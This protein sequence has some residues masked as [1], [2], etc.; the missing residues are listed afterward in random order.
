MKVLLPLFVFLFFNSSILLGQRTI[1]SSGHGMVDLPYNLETHDNDIYFCKSLASEI[2]KFN[3]SAPAPVTPIDVISGN[4]PGAYT[5]S[6]DFKDN[7]LYTGN[8]D[9][10]IYKFDTTSTTPAFEEIFDIQREINSIVFVGNFLYIGTTELVQNPTDPTISNFESKVAKIN[11]TDPTP[12]VTE[13]ITI[14]DL[15]IL[16][17]KFKDDYLY[18]I[19]RPNEIT[20]GQI[21]RFKTTQTNP[22]IETV[23]D[24]LDYPSSFL[25][26]DNL[27]L[28]A[29]AYLHKIIQL[30]ITNPMPTVPT[31]FLLTGAPNTI[32][33][34]LLFG[35]DLYVCEFA[36]RIIA[37]YDVSS[38]LLSNEEFN[39]NSMALKL[40][41]NPS[42]D[43]LTI[44]GLQ[45]HEEYIIY[46]MLGSEVKIGFTANKEYINI[47]ALQ[48]GLY[49]IKLKTGAIFRFVKE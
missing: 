25:I 47:Q 36:D 46:D 2:S 24:N 37:K 29:E 28:I 33:D 34:I 14:P 21:S 17:S 15:S 39:I 16:D 23:T 5:P 26:K 41:P 49:I 19:L 35:N 43:F 18:L 8:S 7:F 9:G 42:H 48:A 13:L 38:I 32:Q 10:K 11:I 4:V 44:S 12:T 1:V 40:Y 30:D 31:D 6:I 3:T 20:G 27:L 22:V 45:N